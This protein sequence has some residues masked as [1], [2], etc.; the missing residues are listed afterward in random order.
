MNLIHKPF[1]KTILYL[2][3]G[4]TSSDSVDKVKCSYTGLSSNGIKIKVNIEIKISIKIEIKIIIESKIKTEIK[5][6]KIN[7]EINNF[8]SFNR[9]LLHLKMHLIVLLK[10]SLR[11]STAMEVRYQ[12]LHLN[13]VGNLY[14]NGAHIISKA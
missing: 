1:H 8:I 5:V 3:P 12:E 9:K 2:F 11:K 6:N 4:I 13:T 14:L 10:S 7:I